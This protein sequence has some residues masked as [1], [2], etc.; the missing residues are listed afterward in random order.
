MGRQLR[1]IAESSPRHGSEEYQV[2][3]AIIAG[4]MV[5]KKFLERLIE[6]Q[7]LQLADKKGIIIDGYPRNTEQIKEFENKVII[8]KIIRSFDIFLYVT[9]FHK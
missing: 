8:N 6:K 9:V 1:N 3:Q 7:L 5:S 2:K 4:E